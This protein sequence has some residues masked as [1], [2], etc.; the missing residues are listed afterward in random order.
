MI[1]SGSLVVCIDDNFPFY[2]W[3]WA[4]DLPRRGKIYTVKE[5]RRGEEPVTGEEGMRIIVMAWWLMRYGEG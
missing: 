2:I 1:V 3:I 5:V 4:E